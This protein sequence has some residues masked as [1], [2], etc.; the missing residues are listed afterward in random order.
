M[1]EVGRPSTGRPSV[2]EGPPQPAVGRPSGRP[3]AGW[4]QGGG[5]GCSRL[6]GTSPENTH[7]GPSR[8][9]EQAW[10]R[11]EQRVGRA[12]GVLCEWSRVPGPARPASPPS[13]ALPG[14][15]SWQP[16]GRHRPAGRSKGCPNRVHP[17]DRLPTCTCVLAA[18]S[19]T[20]CPLTHPGPAPAQER[21]TNRKNNG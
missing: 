12:P 20:L 16:V 3:A 4:V 18:L 1:S 6:V 21:V 17:T 2:E 14:T 5:Q 19:P 15:P 10:Y 11:F 13:Q 9:S 8:P 7:P